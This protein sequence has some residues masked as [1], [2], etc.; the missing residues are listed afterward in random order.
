MN[1]FFGEFSSIP[2]IPP[3]FSSS[4][5]QNFVVDGEDMNHRAVETYVFYVFPHTFQQLASTV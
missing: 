2:L 4:I 1:R 5:S 3:P